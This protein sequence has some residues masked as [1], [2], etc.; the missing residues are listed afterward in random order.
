MQIEPAPG[1]DANDR[2]DKLERRCQRLRGLVVLLI[3]MA[4]VQIAWNM[5][6]APDSVSARRFVLK[7]RSGMPRGEFSIWPDGTPAFRINNDKG[8]ATALW[9]MRQDGTLNLKMNDVHHTTRVEV[10]VDPAGL[11]Y[12]SLFG[13]DGR[14]R[15]RLHVDAEE[16]AEIEYPQR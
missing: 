4:G 1:M 10:G 12:V 11:P 14:S 7:A 5:M 8:E 15:A 9:A 3:L 6:P 16:R 2:L 13:S